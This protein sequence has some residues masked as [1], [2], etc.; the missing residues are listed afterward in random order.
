MDGRVAASQPT[1]GKKEKEG[2][3]RREKRGELGGGN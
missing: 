1:N 2:R 3:S